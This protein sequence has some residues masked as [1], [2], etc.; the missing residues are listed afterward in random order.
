[1]FVCADGVSSR[2]KVPW[3]HRTDISKETNKRKRKLS[4]FLAKPN[5][6]DLQHN[7]SPIF[8]LPLFLL[9][10]RLR[11]TTSSRQPHKDLERVI[12]HPLQ[13][14]QSTNHYNAVSISAPALSLEIQTHLP[15]W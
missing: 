12:D 6:L 3:S 9:L 8:L 5:E 13:A 7:C 2:S 11:P 10:L 15:H 1:M 14:R 4:Q